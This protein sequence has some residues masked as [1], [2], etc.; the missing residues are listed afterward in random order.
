VELS[1]TIFD[2]FR[3]MTRTEQAKANVWAGRELLANT[4]QNV[5]LEGVTA[6][7][8]VLRDGQLV[9][10]QEGGLGV[11]RE[12]Q[13]STSARFD[14]GELTRTDVAQSEARVSRAMSD[15]AQV[16]ANLA[17]SRAVYQR[18]I[19]RPPGTLTPPGSIDPL[20]PRSRDE[21]LTQAETEHPALR[22]AHF[23]IQASDHEIE[24]IKG[25][26]L[27]SLRLEADVTHRWESSDTTL[28]S[29]SASIVGRLTV[30]LYQAGSVSSRVRQARHRSTQ[31]RLEAEDVRS[32]IVASV[33]SAWDGLAAARAQIVA[34][35][36]QVSAATVAV[37]GVREEQRVGQRTT[38]DV[39]DA[40]QELLDAQ[41]S[42]EVTRRNEVVAAYTLL[43]AVG[44]LNAHV[45]GL[46]VAYYDPDEHYSKVRDKWFGLGDDGLH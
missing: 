10:L 43:A 12:E 32:Q 18:V 20:L 13:E 29:D 37:E 46:P 45:L 21:A 3:T 35:R 8:D 9:R 22:S 15:L 23:T 19:G 11:L 40:T 2:G 41:V 39:L 14:V 26:M 6:Y 1:Q 42:L 24:A 31:R 33:S 5:L 4:E 36:Q 7:V 17:T 30:P 27:P 38:L 28:R 25:E 34:D 44:R 16:R